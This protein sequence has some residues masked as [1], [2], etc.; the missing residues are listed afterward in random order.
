MSI[1]LEAKVT[2]LEQQVLEIARLLEFHMAAHR[3]LMQRLEALEQ[4]GKPGPKPKDSNG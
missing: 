2:E 1:A 4:R 3:I